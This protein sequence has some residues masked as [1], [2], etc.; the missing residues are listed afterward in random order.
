MPS[1]ELNGTVAGK[2]STDGVES[3]ASGGHELLLTPGFSSIITKKLKVFAG[4]G[5]P[6]Y[7]NYNESTSGTLGTGYRVTTKI[8]YNW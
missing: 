2:N 5:I 6:I 1:I 4:V 8:S 7:Q 3:D